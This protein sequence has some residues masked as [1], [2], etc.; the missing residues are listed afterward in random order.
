MRDFVLPRPQLSGLYHV[1]AEPIA[2]F[3]LLQLI[4][5]QY[6]KQI[7]ILPDCSLVI[8]RSLNG[9]RFTAMTG[10]QAPAWPQ[11]IETMHGGYQRSSR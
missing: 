2:K 3:D 10:Y 11:L 1:A 8:D 5:G 7:E 4:A 6:G 9:E